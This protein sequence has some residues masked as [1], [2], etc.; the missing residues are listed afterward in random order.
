MNLKQLREESEIKAY[1]VAERLDISRVQF[2]NIEKNYNLN[3]LNIEKLSETYGKSIQEIER[4]C[5]V[6]RCE[7]RRN[8]I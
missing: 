8:T 1:K 4:A 3:M 2:N 7:R 6:I 5:E